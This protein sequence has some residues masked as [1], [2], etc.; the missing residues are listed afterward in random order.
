MTSRVLRELPR[1]TVVAVRENYYVLGS[2]VQSEYV[3]VCPQT[4][5]TRYRMERRKYVVE[6]G[7]LMLIPPFVP[8]VVRPR[9]KTLRKHV[10]HFTLAGNTS[11]IA[12]LPLVIRVPPRDL[13]RVLGALREMEQVWHEK[14]AGWQTVAGGIMAA[15]LGLYIR[16]A[17]SAAPFV[18]EAPRAWKGLEK[19][20]AFMRENLQ[21]DIALDEISAQA[22]LTP[23]YFG[24]I[25]TRYIGMPPHVYLNNC[26]IQQ[27]RHLLING[28]LSCTEVAGMVGFRTVAAFSKVFKRYTSQA[29]TRWL[30]NM[31]S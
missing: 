26:R 3:F 30:R 1:V 17:G 15:L 29:P 10:V 9:E 21:R 13:R 18:E 27:A 28:A 20:M 2:W 31:M 8:H 25:F 4:G 7:M 24:Q 11:A 5:S 14:P 6:P 23:S 22:G 12:G 16:H 19:S